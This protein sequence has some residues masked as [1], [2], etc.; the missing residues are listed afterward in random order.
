VLG[1]AA[2][3]FANPKA[4]LFALAAVGTFLPPDLAPVPAALAVAATS[5]V[6]ILATA[7][8]WAAGGAALNRIVENGRTQRAV[9]LALALLLV[10]SVAFIWI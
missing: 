2:F 6:V 1:G 10:A 7:A 9:S 3:Q 4:W 8:L 5:A